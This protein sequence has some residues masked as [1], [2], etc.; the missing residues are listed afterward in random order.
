MHGGGRVR[1]A[2]E[3]HLVDRG[4][5]Y[6]PIIISNRVGVATGPVCC[7]EPRPETMTRIDPAHAPALAHEWA[8]RWR[9]ESY[10]WNLKPGLPAWLFWTWRRRGVHCRAVIAEGQLEWETPTSSLMYEAWE[11]ADE[12]VTLATKY[13]R[14][15]AVR[16]F[17][18]AI[19][20][21]FIE[22]SLSPDA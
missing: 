9:P 20:W 12:R 21:D 10:T 1:N 3:I 16:R 7:V 4:I 22:N 5:K 14:D 17:G 13:D 2:R 15:D 18:N 19:T 8:S 6:K 11:M